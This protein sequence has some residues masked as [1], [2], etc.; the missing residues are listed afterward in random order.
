MKAAVLTAHGD[1]DVIRYVD[2]LPVPE[3][4]FGEVRVRMKAAAL[5]RLDLFVRRG[6]KGLELDFPHP[7]GSD[8][9]GIINALGP[10]VIG[11][12]IGDAV[13][14][15]P[16]IYSSQKPDGP[17]ENQGKQVGILGEDYPGSARDYAIFPARNLHPVP[18]GFPFADVAAAGLV[19]V[20][21]WHSLITRGHL[22]AGETVLVVGA[23]GGVNSMSIQIAKLAGA[24]VYA[25]GSNAEK[26]QLANDLGADVVINREETP[27]WSRE[28][29]KLTH[30]RGVDVVVDN[31]GAATLNDS[32]RSTAY[33]GRVLIVG[34]TTGYKAEIN[35]AQLFTKHVS[36]I[37][38]TMGTQRDYTQVMDLLFAGRLRAVIGATFPLQEARQAQELLENNAVDGKVVLT[39]DES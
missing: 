29:Y 9:A 17:Y 13:G 22:Q 31:V 36:L 21:A 28:V 15:N 35:V 18:D 1:L 6:W 24:T 7:M 19:G 38:S 30:K 25:V 37:G 32:I 33:G 39:L 16:T 4:G 5:N 27:E 10:D 3:P 34:G 11:W 8:G 26:C 2:D 23:A 14:I 12:Q 20:T